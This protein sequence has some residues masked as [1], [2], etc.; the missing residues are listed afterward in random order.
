MADPQTGDLRHARFPPGDPV[1]PVCA[2]QRQVAGGQLLRFR[3]AQ[4]VGGIGGIAHHHVGAAIDQLAFGIRRFDQGAIRAAQRQMAAGD[5]TADRIRGGGG[6]RAGVVPGM[7]RADVTAMLG[8]GHP[9][10]GIAEC[11][12][13][14][15]DAE[16]TER[17][18]HV[19]YE[20]DRVARVTTAPGPACTAP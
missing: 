17:Y 1:E 3:A 9:G 12:A 16:G 10:A 4:K 18:M 15:Y 2:A 7:A 20:R 11:G 19:W 5:G 14:R 13:Y 6:Q 8:P